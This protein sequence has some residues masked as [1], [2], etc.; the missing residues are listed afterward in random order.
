MLWGLVASLLILYSHLDGLRLSLLS[1]ELNE[2]IGC[3]MERSKKYTPLKCLGGVCAGTALFYGVG[4]S[5]LR[6][7]RITITAISLGFG[8][9][10]LRL[11]SEPT[12]CWEYI[13]LGLL[14][15]LKNK[16]MERITN[17]FL[18]QRVMNVHHM[19]FSTLLKG[20]RVLVVLLS[21]ALS[22]L[23]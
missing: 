13:T 8:Q 20:G 2:K 11:I 14:G 4:I 22:I 12:R 16:Y 17:G 3:L 15:N 23:F 10:A 7:R 5:G 19:E 6:H 21:N 18:G 1:R 9:I